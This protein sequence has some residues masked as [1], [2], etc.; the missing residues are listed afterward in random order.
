MSAT[1]STTTRP[2]PADAG[3]VLESLYQHRLLS[4][5]QVRAMHAPRASLRWT[6]QLLRSLDEHGLAQAVRV[7]RGARKLYF[8]TAAGA[9]AVEQVPTRVETRRKL[10]TPAQALGPLRAHTLAVNDVGIAFQRAA[11]ERGDEC[12]PFAWRHEVAHPIGALPGRRR[13][14]LLICDA[15][16]HYL[17]YGP[18]E[19]LTFHYRFLELDR[20]TIPV[21]ELGAKLARYAR[22]HRFTPDPHPD[23]TDPPRPAWEG[24]YPVFPDVLCVLAHQPRSRLERRLR[25]TINLCRTDPLLQ[26]EDAVQVWLCLLDD[27]LADGPFASIFVSHRQPTQLVDWLGAAITPTSARQRPGA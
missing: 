1:R 11:Q 12:G 14:E 15:V 10:I 13:S 5:T 6:Q 22:L 9:D 20:G 7:G 19:E 21:D 17:L 24:H 2:L 16:L 8:I 4:A 26:R 25:T 23:A 18:D 27:L 3:E